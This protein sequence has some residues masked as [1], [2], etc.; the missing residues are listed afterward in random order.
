MSNAKHTIAVKTGQIYRVPRN[1]KPAHHVKIVRVTKGQ[2]P[3]ARYILVTRSGKR[4]TPKSAHPI[5]AWLQW[6]D[7]SWQMPL[8]WE[9][10]A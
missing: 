7:G 4:K 8:G 9:R 3:K 6:S 5:V 1:G 2:Q 10:L